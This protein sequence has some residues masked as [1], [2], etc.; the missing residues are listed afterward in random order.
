MLSPQVQLMAFEDDV[1]IICTCEIL[2]HMQE[3]IMKITISR[4]IRYITENGLELAIHKTEVLVLSHR[5]KHNSISI[6]IDGHLISSKPN[7]N[8]LGLQ[9]DSRMKFSNH[10]ELASERATTAVK[11][12]NIIMPNFGGP[13]E[14]YRWLIASVN[15]PRLIYAAQIR[16][17]TIS[18]KAINYLKAIQSRS[19]LRVICAYRTISY[20]EA[21]N[22]VWYPPLYLLPKEKREWGN[23]DNDRWTFRVIG[24]IRKWYSCKHGQA[25]YFLTQVLIGHGSFGHYLKRFK[26]RKND[27]I[28]LLRAANDTVEHAVCNCD[29][30]FNARRT[31]CI[32]LGIDEL[33]LDNLSSLLVTA[34]I[35]FNR[36]F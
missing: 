3:E 32:Y 14:C 31:L 29:A 34:N 7:I 24:N 21:T 35:P 33:L 25:S 13:K 6:K 16:Q 15:N 30:W 28:K 1:A 5:R 19:T 8:Y 17:D 18:T 10:A 26:I 22:I 4:I 2:C 27:N 20:N 36:Y 23:A 9:V 11:S 12:L